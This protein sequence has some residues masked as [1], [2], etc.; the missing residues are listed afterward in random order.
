MSATTNSKSID[1]TYFADDACLEIPNLNIM[2]NKLVLYKSIADNNSLLIQWRKV[3]ILLEPKSIPE[4]Q[5]ILDTLHEPYKFTQCK[6][7]SKILGHMATAGK[8]LT[9][10]VNDRIVKT[11][12]DWGTL[13]NTF[14]TN[15][16]I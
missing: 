11:S 14:A 7:K 16:N 4:T 3:F 6:H 13:R 9:N 1:Y 12:D 2:Y 5:S 8:S 15:I 10:D